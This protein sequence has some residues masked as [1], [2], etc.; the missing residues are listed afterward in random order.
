MCPILLTDQN[1]ATCLLLFLEYNAEE[2]VNKTHTFLY[3]LPHWSFL[4]LVR[5]C[6]FRLNW[7]RQSQRQDWKGRSPHLSNLSSLS[8]SCS[9]MQT[10]R[11]SSNK[12]LCL[13]ARCPGGMR[14]GESQYLPQLTSY[15][16]TKY[17][18]KPEPSADFCEGFWHVTR[19]F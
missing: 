19:L 15:S 18:I 7:S 9:C 10:E 11:L 3:Q 17:L 4:R 2:K 1:A 6:H 14:L 8:W 12:T 13:I 16:F 5:W